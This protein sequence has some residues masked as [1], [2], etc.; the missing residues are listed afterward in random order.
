MNEWMNST[1]NQMVL[2]YDSFTSLPL[3]FDELAL[4]REPRQ[5]SAD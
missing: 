4:L 5:G 3:F 2:S 1:Y